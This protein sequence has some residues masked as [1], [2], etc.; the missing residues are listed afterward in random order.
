LGLI[1][2]LEEVS[3]GEGFL[4]P[5]SSM[6]RIGSMKI[7]SIHDLFTYVAQ[8]R[9]VSLLFAMA[10]IIG[11]YAI[12]LISPQAKKVI[13]LFGKNFHAQHFLVLFLVLAF[14]ASVI[15]LEIL[16]WEALFAL[17]EILELNASLALVFCC[18]ALRIKPTRGAG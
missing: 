2:F 16:E 10:A 6:P 7:D 14:V 5:S 8:D 13:R 18:L 12:A 4:L 9:P 11:L 1:G 17:E 3:F 15:D